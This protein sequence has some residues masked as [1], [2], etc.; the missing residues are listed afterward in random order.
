MRYRKDPEVPPWDESRERSARRR[1]RS[2]PI[3]NPDFLKEDDPA[4]AIMH[5]NDDVVFVYVPHPEDTTYTEAPDW[6]RQHDV[7]IN[8]L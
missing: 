6:T 5:R 1:R 4:L 7:K 2:R 8:V 3:D